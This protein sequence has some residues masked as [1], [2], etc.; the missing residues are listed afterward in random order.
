MASPMSVGWEGQGGRWA[1]AVG[2]TGQCYELCFPARKQAA[3]HFQRRPFRLSIPPTPT[4]SHTVIPSPS[5]KH[6]TEENGDS[7]ENGMRCG[8]NKKT[9]PHWSPLCQL[10]VLGDV[11]GR[12]L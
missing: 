2:P 11:G 6:S 12:D 7:V 10:L 1:E 3:S 9:K 4:P 5:L 8:V